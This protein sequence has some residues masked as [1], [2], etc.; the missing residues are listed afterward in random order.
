[1]KIARFKLFSIS[2]LSSLLVA[3]GGGG[4]N[5]GDLT[6]FSLSV[7]EITWTGGSGS[8]PGAGNGTWVT[9][10]GGQ[11]PFRV[12]NPNPQFVQVDRT[13]VTGKDPVF[14]IT[15]LGA[16]CA[17]FSI[18]VLDYHSRV[19]NIDVKLNEGEDAEE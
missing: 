4:D 11:A 18:S 13:E 19:A 17:E 12:R 3:C 7:D 2:L 16:G 14:K 6:D 1:M 5:A 15:T 9:I 8:C 10:I